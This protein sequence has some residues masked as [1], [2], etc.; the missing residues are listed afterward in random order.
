MKDNR[1]IVVVTGMSGAGKTTALK[2]LEDIGYYCVDNLPP[3]M[4]PRFAEVCFKAGDEYDKLALGIDIRG[5]RL[6][7][8]LIPSIDNVSNEDY[9]LTVIYLDSDDETLLKRFKETRRSHPLSKSERLIDGIKEE[10]ELTGGVKDRATYVIDTSRLLSRELKTEINRIFLTGE[11]FSGLII[12]IVS[13]G[14]KYGLPNDADLVFDVRF[15]PN[16]FY[17]PELKPLTGGNAPVADYVMSFDISQ[18]FLEKAKEM[19]DLLIPAYIAEGK[20]KLVVCIG[21]TGGRHRS[22]AVSNDI[23]KYLSN[24]GHSVFLSHRDIMLFTSGAQ[25]I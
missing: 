15:T 10:R 1:N 13:F 24:K 3:A 18:K 22:V 12:N 8:D 20:N 4:I 16:P 19:L 23:F 9:K 2:F 6:F 25:N 14:F 21:C 5:G 17:I 7:N 11:K